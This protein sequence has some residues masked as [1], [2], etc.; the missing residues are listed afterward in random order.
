MIDYLVKCDAAPYE[1]T[2]CFQDI[3]RAWDLCYNLSE[4]YGYAYVAYYDI[5]GNQH[6]VGEYTNGR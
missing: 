5:H 4:E 1:N 2:N 6:I 3:D